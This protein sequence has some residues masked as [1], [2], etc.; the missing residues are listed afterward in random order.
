MLYDVKKIDSIEYEKDEEILI[1]N[2]IKR[3]MEVDVFPTPGKSITIGKKKYKVHSVLLPDKSK[4]KQ[5]GF[6]NKVINV[7]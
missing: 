7:R 6:K 2:V 1:G 3:N 4:L 5:H